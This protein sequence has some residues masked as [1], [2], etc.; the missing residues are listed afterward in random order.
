MSPFL[1]A[2]AQDDKE[3]KEQDEE[4]EDQQQNNNDDESKDEDN[5]S[6]DEDNESKDGDEEEQQTTPSITNETTQ[7]VVN[8]P[9]E[10]STP[11]SQPV[12]NEGMQFDA[13]CNCTTAASSLPSPTKPTQPIMQP[14][15]Q[16]QQTNVLQQ[17]PISTANI[18]DSES[19]GKV[20]DP[21]YTGYYTVSNLFDNKLDDTSFWSQAGNSGFY[22][23][24]DSTLDDYQ[25]CSMEL[26]NIPTNPTKNIPFV[27][28]LFV[29]KNYTGVIDSANERIQFD[30][31][32][33]NMDQIL[34]IFNP[35][36]AASNDFISI[37]EIKLFGNKLGVG[38]E[39]IP[40]THPPTVPPPSSQPPYN[41]KN[42]TKINISNSDALIDIKNST[43]TFKFD[44]QS[45]QATGYNIITIP[46]SKVVN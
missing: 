28:D 14:T 40:T 43:V 37:G 1:Y 3:D 34:L 39:P 13:T 25:V 27:L 24:L 6:K 44:P 29:L 36:N 23:R 32:I 18:V 4:E 20:V 21:A 33:K 8:P 31:C 17:I 42:A 35:E 2:Y 15:A 41:N 46:N 38:G 12:V 30:K 7:P 9:P 45:A 10:V 16:Q 22:I 5:E 26:S 11:P 19:Q